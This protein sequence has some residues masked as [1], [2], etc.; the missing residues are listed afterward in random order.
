MIQ[1]QGGLVEVLEA[2]FVEGVVVG[3]RLANRRG[4]G[5]RGVVAGQRLAHGIEAAGGNQVARKGLSGGGVPNQ[6][7]VGQRGEGTEVAR[8]HIGGG[9]GR[10]GGDL[11]R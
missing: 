10:Q 1:S 5:R 4:I 2:S 7:G 6:N 9:H 8:Q 11:L 3:W